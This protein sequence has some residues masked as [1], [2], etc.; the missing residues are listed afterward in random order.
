MVE[1]SVFPIR[2]QRPL[3]FDW[4]CGDRDKLESNLVIKEYSVPIFHISGHPT[5]LYS[6]LISHRLI[7]LVDNLSLFFFLISTA[8]GATS[9]STSTTVTQI[10]ALGT[11]DFRV[12]EEGSAEG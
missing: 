4:T 12:E 1:A 5:Y 9:S 10:R 7:C 6:A 8:P 2:M 3:I 11:R